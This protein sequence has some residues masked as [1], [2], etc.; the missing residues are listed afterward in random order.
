[1]NHSWSSLV[2]GGEGSYLPNC[3]TNLVIALDALS[4]LFCIFI[5]T[6][7][8]HLISCSAAVTIILLQRPRLLIINWHNRKPLKWTRTEKL[9]NGRFLAQNV[10]WLSAQLLLN[11]FKGK[12]SKAQQ[13]VVL[14]HSDQRGKAAIAQWNRL[15]LPS[16]CPRFESQAHHLRLYHL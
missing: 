16:C 11:V 8:Y 15:Y 2:E 1:M 7:A 10:E 3:Q 4:L 6:T 14:T 5:N 12:N 9:E 13:N